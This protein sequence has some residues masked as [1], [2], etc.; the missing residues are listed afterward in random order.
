MRL[1]EYKKGDSKEEEAGYQAKESEVLLVVRM[2]L[3]DR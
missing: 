1:N 3:Q 2:R